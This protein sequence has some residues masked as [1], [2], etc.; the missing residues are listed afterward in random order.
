MSAGSAVDSERTTPARRGVFYGYWVTAAGFALC[1]V[2]GGLYFYGFGAFFK[3]ITEELGTSRAVLSGA[4]SLARL[5][6]GLIG[7][8]E[9][10]L[11][12]RFGPRKVL[13]AGIPMM[14][15]GFALMSLV[16]SVLMFY[17]VFIFCLSFGSSLASVAPSAA[18]VVNWFQ[19]KRSRMLGIMLAG[20]GLGSVMV[21]IVTLLIIQLGWRQS[22]LVL[23]AIILVVGLPLAAV[24][25]H[26]PEQYGE[27]PDGEQPPSATGECDPH[28]SVGDERED[29][30]TAREALRTSAF[31]L[32]SFAFA[33]RVG[34]TGS[35]ALHFIPFLTDIGVGLGTAGLMVT[36]I[37]VVGITGR[38]AFGWLGD[39][40]PKRYVVTGG[41]CSLALGLLVLAFATTLWHVALALVLYAPAYGGLATMMFAMRSEYFGRKS[42]ATI[43]GFMG[44]VLVL[45]TVSGPV[46]AG[47][48]FDVTHS[49]R[50]A[51]ITFAAASALAILLILAAKPVRAPLA[52][53]AAA[54]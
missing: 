48:I 47:W 35:V 18:A 40:F 49:Y 37:G 12:D 52:R 21:P 25:R 27:F 28:P 6:G 26:K 11:I 38:L 43:Q 36:V 41:L 23:A 29:G 39:L 50:I 46:Y 9:G 44:S 53:E 3:T 14:A 5:E 51:F 20:N 7:P 4:F 2:N 13:F 34:V 22:L 10:W 15:A 32:M 30:L 31:W 54:V 1:V 24:M 17:V 16:N 19:R 33:I 42:F 45:G 8:L